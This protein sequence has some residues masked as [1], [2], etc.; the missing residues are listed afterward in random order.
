MNIWTARLAAEKDVRTLSICCPQSPRVK[1]G[2]MKVL[3][4]NRI[5]TS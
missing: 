4:Y 3:V 5:I 2:T 1:K